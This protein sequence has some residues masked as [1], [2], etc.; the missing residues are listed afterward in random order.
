ML[1]LTV[2]MRQ[3]GD[4]A[5]S[6]LLCRVRTYSCTSDDIRTHEIAA[7]AAN[8]PSQALRVYRLNVA[9]D[10]RNTRMLNNLKCTVYD[11]SY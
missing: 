3:R 5:F 6:E 1:E 2:V 8:Y 10:I 7:D 9:V 4:H 11:K